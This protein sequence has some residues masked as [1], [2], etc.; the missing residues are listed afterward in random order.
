LNDSYVKQ[1][2]LVTDEVTR[3]EPEVGEAVEKEMELKKKH[4]EARD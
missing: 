3:S 1:K 2:K 4:L